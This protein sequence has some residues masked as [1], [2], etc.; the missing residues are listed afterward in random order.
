MFDGKSLGGPTCSFASV[1]PNWGEI[2]SDNLSS[3]LFELMV[4][5]SGLKCAA[6][7]RMQGD[8]LNYLQ[9]L[10]EHGINSIGTLLKQDPFRLETVCAITMVS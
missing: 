8:E 5:F 7:F 10:A 1:G 6:L 4:F 3:T 2:V 9:V